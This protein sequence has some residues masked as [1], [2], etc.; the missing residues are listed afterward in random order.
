MTALLASGQHE[1]KSLGTVYQGN[2]IRGL[3]AAVAFHI[4]LIG[5]FYAVGP[6][7][8][9]N[10]LTEKIVILGG[11]AP[12]EGSPTIAPNIAVGG[13]LRATAKG[14]PVPVKEIDDIEKYLQTIVGPGSS[15]PGELDVPGNGGEGIPGGE[16]V[17]QA[18]VPGGVV[19]LTKE[20][21]GSLEKYPIPI[22]EVKP[23]YPE[24]ARRMGVEGTVTV[25]ILIDKYGKPEKAEILRTD[26]E[27]LNEAAIQAA[28]KWLFVPAVM[29]NNTV[30]VWVA[31]PFR[32]R[33]VE[34]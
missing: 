16:G 32:F 13:G 33:V 15:N 14:I 9:P 25:K 23:E 12:W 19:D 5:L 2:S 10:E 7:D 11:P 17:D 24:L 26:T 27:L 22:R 4:A 30:A 21:K 6:V 1:W 20:W 31:V 3:T 29:N 34:K 18:G 8:R 28:M